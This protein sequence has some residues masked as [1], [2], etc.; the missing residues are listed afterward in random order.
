[1]SVQALVLEMVHLRCPLG[2]S[3]PVSVPKG[4]AVVIYCRKCGREWERVA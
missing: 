4:T 3:T 1:M 2:H